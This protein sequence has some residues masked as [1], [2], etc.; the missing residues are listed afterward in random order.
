MTREARVPDALGR[1]ATREVQQSL[2]G[3]QETLETLQGRLD[4]TDIAIEVALEEPG[5]FLRSPQALKNL[6]RAVRDLTGQCDKIV[7]ALGMI[8]HVVS[9]QGVHPGPSG[10][11]R[12]AEM[13]F[14]VRAARVAM[15]W[16]FNKFNPSELLGQLKR[17]LL[18]AGL[19]EV[20]QQVEAAKV[21][22]LVNDAWQNRERA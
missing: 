2:F 14:R 4:Q 1:S 19:D 22:R 8:H 5:V 17:V 7:G 10:L 18:D 11:H 16:A 20:W 12:I 6:D 9:E 15:R 13:E 3:I 21:P